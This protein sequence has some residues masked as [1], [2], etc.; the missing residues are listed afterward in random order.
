MRRTGAAHW[1]RT[2]SHVGRFKDYRREGSRTRRTRWTPIGC[3]RRQSRT[4]S[5][6]AFVELKE[7]VY[8]ITANFDALIARAVAAA[9]A[10]QP[11][12]R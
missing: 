9:Q 7:A 10:S 8:A 4:Y 2:P 6:R 5:R 3:G 12:E 1:L 11:E